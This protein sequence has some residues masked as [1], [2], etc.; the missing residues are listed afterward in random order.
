M[1]KTKKT[2]FFCQ[3][4]GHEEAKWLGQCP[5]CKEWNTFVEEKKIPEKGSMTRD[6]EKA[7][8]VSLSQIETKGED[9]IRTEMEELDRQRLSRFGGRGS[10]NRKVHAAFADVPDSG[11]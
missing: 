6:R 5:A 10:G 2:V 11:R 8:P 4:C 9:R 3:N 1:A 7:E